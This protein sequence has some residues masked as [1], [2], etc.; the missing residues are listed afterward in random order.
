[1]IDMSSTFAGLEIARSALTASQI[2][3]NV[4]SQNIANANTEDYTRQT[5][6]LVAVNY[7]AGKYRLAQSASSNLGQGVSVSKISQIRDGFLDSQVRSA[8]SKYAALDIKQ[9][10]LTDIENVFDETTTDGLHTTLNDFYTEL[11]SLSNNVGND[12]YTAMVRSAAEKVTSTLNQYATQLSQIQENQELGL[13]LAVEDI[14]TLVDKINTTNAMIKDQ[15][16][17]GNVSNELLD[18]RNSYL[19]TLSGQ[20]NITVSDNMDGTISVKS[21]DVDVLNS[22]FSI[23]SVGED[24]VVQVTDLDGNVENYS[25]SEGAV[26]GYL[27]VLNGAGSYAE[28][29]GNS[30][31]GI[32]YYSKAL[33]SFAAA[34]A[35]T[36]NA[37]NTLDTASPANLFT[38]TTAADIA[39]SDEWYADAG[40]IVEANTGTNDNVMKM[41]NAMD[42]DIDT[43]TYEGISSTFE[44]FSRVLMNAIAV[45]VGYIS[46]VKTMNENILNVAVNERESVMGVS[47]DEETVNM[48]TYQKAFQ[49]ASRL[50]TVFDENLN[51]IINSMGLVGR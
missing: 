2:S 28:A 3:L 16:L 45:D 44:G 43:D 5:A 38:G 19:D 24:T 46:D 22:T 15:T 42:S 7:G 21:G 41:I 29:D 23:T 47:I 13:E 37:I 20:I 6:D 49:A 18:Q 11:E 1:M 27:D 48:L 36:F 8:N 33:D 30:F 35:G 34:F 4:T 26:K 32:A 12:E 40:Y 51:T 9:S 25:P 31:R 14:N 17:R 50:I 10:A 39:I